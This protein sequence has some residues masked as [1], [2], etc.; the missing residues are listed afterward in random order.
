MHH[1]I[2]D[3]A[4]ASR[5]RIGS[6]D[7]EIEPIRPAAPGRL[8]PQLLLSDIDVEEIASKKEGQPAEDFPSDHRLDLSERNSGNNSVQDW[9]WRQWKDLANTARHREA[10][11]H[12]IEKSLERIG[13]ELDVLRLFVS[14][15][16]G[17]DEGRADR[18]SQT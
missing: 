7:Y 1:I 13:T 6:T 18:E 10:K 8:K 11:I 5:I 16:K 9:Q 17:G 12:F 15:L 14:E 2:I 4:G 3:N